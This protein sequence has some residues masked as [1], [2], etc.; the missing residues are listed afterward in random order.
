MYLTSLS[1]DKINPIDYYENYMS[2][3][4]NC[5]CQLDWAEGRPES[6]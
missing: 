1:F 6:W 2:M 4:V 3:M 5:M